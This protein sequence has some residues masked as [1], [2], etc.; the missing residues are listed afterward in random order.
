MP[1]HEHG[2]LGAEADKDRQQIL[3]KYADLFALLKDLNSICHEYLR[4]A[5][6]NYQSFPYFQVSTYFM[7]GLMTFQ[8][9]VILS[10]RGCIEDVRAL[11]RTLLQ[12]S[13]RLAAIAVDSTVIYRIPGQ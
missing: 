11:C 12:A 3:Q 7:R 8:S 10:E 4:T 2:F 5:K 9:L 6:C 1:L 13:V